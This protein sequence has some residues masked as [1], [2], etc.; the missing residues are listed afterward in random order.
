VTRRKLAIATLISFG[1]W[2]ALACG[3]TPI[4]A[5]VGDQNYDDPNDPGQTGHNTFA[6]EAGDANGKFCVAA[7]D[8]PATFVCAYSIADACGAA[9]RCLPYTAVAGCENNLACACD[10]TTVDLC[11][12]S[13][14]AAKPVSSVGACDGGSAPDTGTADSGSDGATTDAASADAT[15]D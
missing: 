3:D 11:A 15:S 6:P 8:C 2:M 7:R 10:G 1:A 14:Y 5:P 9:G 13:G 12:P 4:G